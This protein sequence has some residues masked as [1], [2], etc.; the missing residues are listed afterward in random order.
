MNI[1][2]PSLLPDLPAITLLVGPAASGK[3]EAAARTFQQHAR[4]A[5]IMLVPTT[6]HEQQL[7]AKIGSTQPGEVCQFSGLA[8]RVLRQAG[9]AHAHLDSTMRLMLLRAL[10]AELAATGEL[11]R[12]APVAHMPGWIATIGELITEMEEAESDPTA[13]AAAQVSRC[14]SEVAAIYRAYRA[15]VERLDVADAARR[16]ALARDTLRERPGLLANLSLLVVDGFDQFTPLQISLLTEVA[17]SA[18]HTLLTLTWQTGNR[19]THH[20]FART[21]AALVQRLHPTVESIARDPWAALVAPAFP[22]PTHAP[23][24]A[25]LHAHLFD[26][27]TPPPVDGMGA[28]LLIEAADREREVR[29]ALR[30]VRSLIEG[31]TPPHEIAILFRSSTPYNALLR[32]VAAEYGLPLALYDG[33][34]LAEA[35]PVAAIL[36]MLR[37]PLARYPRRALVEVWRSMADGRIQLSPTFFASPVDTPAPTALTAHAF[38]AAAHELDQFAR[39]AGIASGLDR[40]QAALRA[41]AQAIPAIP[42]EDD[43]TNAAGND[44]EAPQHPAISPEAASH[45]LALLETFAAW[46]TPPSTAT[47]AAYAAWVGQRLAS[48][49]EWGQ[50]GETPLHAGPRWS[51][52]VQRWFEVV[53]SLARAAATLDEPP[54]RYETFI[55]ELESAVSAARYGRAEPG[56]GSVAALNVLAARGLHVDHLLI[57]GMVES[58]FPLALGEPSIYSRR[59]RAALSRCGVPLRAPDPADERSLFYETVTRARTSLTLARTYLDERGNPL[60]PS[61]YLAALLDL[62]QPA[63]VRRVRVAAGSVPTLAAAASPH[64]K[65]VAHMATAAPPCSPG[66]EPDLPLLAHVH[67][68]CQVEQQ[69]EAAAACGPFEGVLDDAEVRAAVARHF[70]PTHRWSITQFHDYITC[71]FRFAAAHL[72]RLQPRSDPE[73]DLAASGRGRIYHDIL[74][75]A[76]KAWIAHGCALRPD[77][78]QPVTNLLRAAADTL[79]A[80]AP[81]RY[82]FEPGPLWEWEHHDI[83]RRLLHALHRFIHEEESWHAFAP[84]EVERGFGLAYGSSNPDALPPLRLDTPHGVVLVCGRVDR[85]DQ[86]ADGALALLDYKSSSKPTP[87]PETLEGSNVQ[88]T[89]YLL[90]VETVLAPGQRVEQAAFAHLGSGKYSRPLTSQQREQALTAMRKQVAETVASVRNGLFPVHPRTACASGCVFAGI[91]R[92]NLARQ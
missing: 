92:V 30:H 46:L 23:V 39:E 4:G 49:A 10:L 72:L 56:H 61:P 87:L 16:L 19:P 29:A 40:L 77:Q 34:P 35:P 73:D 83:R 55:T 45:L 32:E 25:H 42:A 9:M 31:G 24:L 1:A 53:S 37:L 75:E 54:V 38:E 17:R 13:L 20:R 90:A 60:P 59:E 82:G 15:R 6:L 41:R 64:E 44:E 8:A 36:A 85:I 14:D 7:A 91:C 79:L 78:E 26:I 21:Y 76:G 3:T 12:F 48:E 52:V 84:V 86:R 89:I 50:P 28:L 57:L 43:A 69:R 88:L 74:A 33:L 58:E 18:G 65:L 27:E 5:G 63:T 22:H 62:V 66:G 47:P 71:P 67:R 11:P 80:E 2:P 70:G 81:H 68:A 51:H